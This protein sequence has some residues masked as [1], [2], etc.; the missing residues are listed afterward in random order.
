MSLECYLLCSYHQVLNFLLFYE[1]MLKRLTQDFTE[2]DIEEYLFPRIPI[3]FQDTDPREFE[4][5]IAYLFSVNG[6]I[7][8]DADYSPDFGADLIV[9]YEGKRSAVQIKRYHES[10]RVGLQEVRQLI[11]AKEYYQ[12]DL[13]MLISTSSFQRSA[14]KLGE[15]EEAILWDWYQLQQAIA[16]TFFQGNFQDYFDRYPVIQQP[17][18]SNLTFTLTSI[19]LGRP[20]WSFEGKSTVYGELHNRSQNPL[21]IYLDLPDYLTH[22]RRQFR[23]LGW[24]SQSFQQGQIM[25]EAVVPL[26]FSFASKQLHKYHR[27]DRIVLRVHSIETGD[28]VQLESKMKDLKKQFFLVGWIRSIL[29]RFRQE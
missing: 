2:V 14:R 20:N 19:D 24:S 12:C 29:G 23:S 3:R 10:H 9:S 13:A 27:H 4:S 18:D 8:E 28:L 7:L 6:Y 15:E 11:S 17:L 25:G 16:D 26:I 1:E 21:N 22:Q 5:F